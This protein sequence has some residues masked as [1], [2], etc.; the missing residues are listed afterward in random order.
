MDRGAWW[1]TLHGVAKSWTRLSEFCVCSEKKTN[2]GRGNNV[3]PL[4]YWFDSLVEGTD[5]TKIYIPPISC[6]L[7]RHFTLWSFNFIFPIMIFIYL[8]CKCQNQ[9]KLGR[10]L[11]GV[12]MKSFPVN[13]KINGKVFKTYLST[14]CSKWQHE[15]ELLRF[16]FPQDNC[17]LPLTCGLAITRYL[18]LWL[19]LRDDQDEKDKGFQTFAIS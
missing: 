18:F 8:K 10:G 1:A 3:N 9:K 5:S 14:Q 13:V 19:D 12:M 4:R 6:Y 17:P 2:S 11:L 7:L 15:M 16:D